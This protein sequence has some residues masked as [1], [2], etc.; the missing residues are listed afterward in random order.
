MPA[1]P[2]PVV[3]QDKPRDQ[4]ELTDVVFRLGRGKI[5]EHEKLVRRR[6]QRLARLVQFP[7]PSRD[8][9]RTYSF[10]FDLDMHRTSAI[11]RVRDDIRIGV[12]TKIRFGVRASAQELRSDQTLSRVPQLD[13]IRCVHVWRRMLPLAR[14]ANLLP[15]TVSSA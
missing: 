3:L 14:I 5:N 4:A 8:L 15:I 6:I 2:V 12:T 7:L 10:R 11:R 9:L 13:W 1:E